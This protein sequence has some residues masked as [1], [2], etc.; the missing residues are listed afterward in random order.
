MDVKEFIAEMREKH[1]IT[2]EPSL[3]GNDQYAFCDACNTFDD[4]SCDVNR[5]LDLLEKHLA[6]PPAQ[7]WLL[8]EYQSRYWKPSSNV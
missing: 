8:T 6:Q 1:E 3:D 5:V 2:I 4:V 7:D